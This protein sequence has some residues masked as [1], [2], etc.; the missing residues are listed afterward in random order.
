[1][2]LDD[3]FSFDRKGIVLRRRF[4]WLCRTLADLFGGRLL[5]KLT[6]LLVAA[7]SLLG[8]FVPTVSLNKKP[9]A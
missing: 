2:P 5:S 3:T 1:M 8:K 4:V 9:D 6:D 7:G